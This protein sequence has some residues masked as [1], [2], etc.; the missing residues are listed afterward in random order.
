L[1][2][3]SLLNRLR[4]KR[5]QNEF[6]GV[7]DAAAL[8]KRQEQQAQLVAAR[9]A[10]TKLTGNSPLNRALRNAFS[11]LAAESEAISQE[12]YLQELASR[13]AEAAGGSKRVAWLGV[14]YNDLSWHDEK[15]KVI[16]QSF[17]SLGVDE[18]YLSW[19]RVPGGY[20]GT[21]AVPDPQH[22]SQWWDSH[23][24]VSHFVPVSEAM[25]ST[26][27][28]YRKLLQA[29]A[30]GSCDSQFAV[31]GETTCSGL[32]LGLVPVWRQPDGSFVASEK[33]VAGSVRAQSFTE[34]GDAIF[35]LLLAPFHADFAQ[36]R[37]LILSPDGALAYLP[38]ETLSINGISILDTLD[39]AY[40]QSLAVHEELTNRVRAKKV[41]GPALLSFADPDYTLV[42]KKTA[43]AHVVPRFLVE[44]K[45]P[46]LAGTQSES[47]ALLKL[48]TGGLQRLGAKASR[49][50]LNSLQ[51]SGK[52]GKY[53]VLHFAT[54]GYVDD[55]RS[56]LVLSMVDGA[57]QGY[58][59]DT[60]VLDLH[61]NTDLVLLSACNTG[62]GR[63]VSGEGVM[64]LPYAFMLAGNSNTLM[65]LW[66]VEDTGTAAFMTTFM[67]K[68]HSGMDLFT[69]LNQTKREFAH[70]LHGK[71]FSDPLIWAAFVQYGIG[72]TLRQ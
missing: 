46:G 22:V 42:T 4:I 59:Q 24:L 57:D 68:V 72:T 45:W 69:A 56:A 35:T 33:P 38:F 39:I 23:R 64:G 60:D 11:T 2:A 50:Q 54:H 65:S 16:G 49:K 31:A 48:F 20:V 10:M 13:K 61:L 66:S 41:S 29:G 27:D 55:E 19:L 51:R 5:W 44:A 53:R 62:I 18:A 14:G 17:P 9:D 32:V 15:K 3:Q 8:A 6:A 7:R 1:R 25:A 30:I 28:L 40:V 26:L 67:E 70:G 52:L 34:L 43:S 71:V 21:L 58:L 12:T 36:V 47:D 63:N 37:R